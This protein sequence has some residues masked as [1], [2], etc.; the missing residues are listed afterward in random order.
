M[1]KKKK[2]NYCPPAGFCRVESLVSVDERGQMV[3]P[4]EIREKARI[5]PGD[6]LAVVTWEREG[7][8]CCISLVKA[9]E[10]VGMVKDR[11]G[12]VMKEIL[13]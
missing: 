8:V 7:K 11:L 9:D 10:L 2:E 12:P 3:L 6:K 4:K 5:S 13:K 1:V